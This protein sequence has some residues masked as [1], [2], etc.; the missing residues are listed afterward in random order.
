MGGC[1]Q[2]GCC[3]GKGGEAF[4][5]LA[6]DE[7]EIDFKYYKSNNDKFVLK[8]ETNQNVL[9]FISL[10]EFI[11][12]L[13]NFSPET[14]TLPFEE[15]LKI[16]FSSK[17]DFLYK[18]MSIDEFQSFIENKIMKAKDVYEMIVKEPEIKEISIDGMREVYQSLSKKLAQHYKE[19]ERDIIIRRNILA[20]GILY[21]LTNNIG[22]IRVF[23]DV[24]ANE[25]N[26]FC[27]SE[28]LDNFML[29]LFI[30]SSYAIIASRNKVSKSSNKFKPLTQDELREAISI[31]ELADCEKLLEI[32]NKD[33]FDKD[34]F[35]YDEFKQKFI[36]QNNGFGWIF[37]PQG[38]RFM[39]E[40]HNQ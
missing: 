29:S 5:A 7:K 12:M 32:F 40:K 26:K 9:S 18:K 14:A 15:P 33:F 22:K 34:C 25:E 16:K 4:N 2:C 37:S 23:F 36:D 31:S 27:K 6:P 1:C 10:V 3:G 8:L 20:M 17:D 19:N 11:N 39:L 28:E 38:V 21:C 30:L 13:E 35:T 24:F